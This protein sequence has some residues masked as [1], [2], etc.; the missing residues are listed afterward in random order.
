MIQLSDIC[1]VG[2]NEGNWAMS[3]FF[4]CTVLLAHDAAVLTFTSLARVCTV[5]IMGTGTRVS[6]GFDERHI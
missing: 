6:S 4:P 5:R 1:M 3:A 2:R